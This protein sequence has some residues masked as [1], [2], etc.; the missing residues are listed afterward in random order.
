M[1]GHPQPGDVLHFQRNV[2]VD[3]VVAEDVPGF[4]EFAVAVERRQRFVER[5]ATSLQ[6]FFLFR[7]AGRRGPCPWRRPGGS[8]SGCRRDRPASAPKTRDRGWPWSPGSAPRCGDLSD[9][10]R[11]ECESTPNGS[12]QSRP[13]SSAPR[14][15]GPG[16]CSCWCRVGERVDRLRVFDDA[17]DVIQRRVREPAIAVAGEQV[18]A[19]FEQRLMDVHATTVVVDQRFRHEGRRFSVAVR[20]VVHDVF[21]RLYFVGLLQQRV[22]TTPISHWPA[23]ATS[24]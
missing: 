18:F 10:T 5:K 20:D 6:V 7:A 3:Q 16:V 19:A 15:R 2:G 22:E 9:W 8:C 24:W 12:A 11:T 21:Q 13:G 4:Q 23:V 14:N 17:A 1:R